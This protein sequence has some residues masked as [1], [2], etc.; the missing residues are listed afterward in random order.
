MKIIWFLPSNSLNY[1]NLSAS[2]WIRALQLFKYLENMQVENY[3]NDECINGEIA[4]FVRRQSANDYE[5]ACSLKKRGIRIIFDLCVNYFLLSG[6]PGLNNP[7]T[8]EHRY[9]CIKM[10]EM[11]DAIFCASEEIRKYAVKFNKKSFYIPDSIDL[12]HFKKKKSIKDF[13]RKKIRAIWSGISVKAN[14][15][16]EYMDILNELKIPLRIISEKRPK[17]FTP[18]YWVGG[19]KSRF[20]KWDFNTFPKNI[21]DGEFTISP[22]D[23][24]ESYNRGH[25][26]F[27]IGVFLAVGVPAIVS[28]IPS[29]K[30]LLKNGRCGAICYSKKQFRNTM[31]EVV[32]N[33]GILKKWSENSISLMK[34]YSSEEITKKYLFYFIKILQQG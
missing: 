21:L 5:I 9:N 31:K 32:S 17:G 4:I 12:N 7:V 19:Y 23:L 33:R 1:N 15:L 8:E 26:F 13:D 22:G 6:A 20:T 30:E 11:S 24:S 16:L 14:E 34:K 18:T 10:S 2:V 28:P 27:K 3:V 29:Y 25:S